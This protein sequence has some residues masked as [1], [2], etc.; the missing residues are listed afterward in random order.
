MQTILVDYSKTPT[1]MLMEADLYA[2]WRLPR[3]LFIA[4]KKEGSHPLAHENYPMGIHT[5]NCEAI[6]TEKFMSIPEMNRVL[7]DKELRQ[8]NTEELIAY[9]IAHMPKRFEKWV[10]GTGGEMWW[11]QFPADHPVVPAICQNQID[12][13]PSQWS[14]KDCYFL[15]VKEITP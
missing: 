10:F 4:D 2:S 14:Y 6:Y 15:G 1:E 3:R 7:K 9:A 5:L 11:C 8:A 13:T 12:T